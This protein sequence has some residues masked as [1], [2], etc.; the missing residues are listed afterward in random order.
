MVS[1]DE[2]VKTA[3]KVLQQV[4]E[5]AQGVVSLFLSFCSYHWSE[6]EINVKWWL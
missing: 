3:L 2:L 1:E 4:V 6:C 5:M